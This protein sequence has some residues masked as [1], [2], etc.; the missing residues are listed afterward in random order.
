[1]T[2]DS[3]TSYRMKHRP[4]STD[5]G[6]PAYDLTENGVYPK[7][8]YDHPSWYSSGEDYYHEAWSAVSHVRGKPDR[9]IF[10]HRAMPCGRE[11]K[12][13]RNGDWVT[14]VKKYARE[15][16]KHPSD[17]SKDM[18]IRSIRV[19]AKC[20]HTD[21]NSLMEWGYNCEAREGFV[22]FRPRKRK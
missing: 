19:K 17:P 10:V 4:P 5:D 21:G 22:S 20:I 2:K 16:G 18:C 9:H 7:D 12:T 1:M 11:F 8:V 13:I 15:H 14:T 3:D 6:A